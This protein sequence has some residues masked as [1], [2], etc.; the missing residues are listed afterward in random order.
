MKSKLLASLI[1]LCGL[2]SFAVDPV[3]VWSGDFNET[4]KGDYTLSANGNTVAADGLSITISTAK[5]VSVKKTAGGN[6]GDQASTVIIKYTNFT[7]PTNSDAQVL[8]MNHTANTSYKDFIGAASISGGN[9]H[10][11]WQNTTW[12]AN[13]TTSGAYGS[14]AT[15]T[16]TFAFTWA[17]TGT[18]G[19]YF[20]MDGANKN[21]WSTLHGN[22]Q[23]DGVWVGGPNESTTLKPATGMKVLAIAVFDSR[24]SDAEIAAY[25]FPAPPK[26]VES[27]MLLN[28]HNGTTVDGWLNHTQS[29]GGAI[30]NSGSLTTNGIL[31]VT[32]SEGNF[33]TQR[34]SGT[35]FLSGEFIGL[36]GKTY[37]SIAS[38]VS[39]SLGLPTGVV[40]DDT[41]Y[42]TGVMNGGKVNHTATLSGLDNS[43][44]YLLYIGCG[45]DHTDA[46][47]QSGFKFETS[48]CASVDEL[49]YVN[50]ESTAYQ[51]GNLNTD[52]L[53]TTD[54]LLIV[55]VKGI[56][57]VNGTIQFKMVG[58]RSSLNFLAV[59]KMNDVATTAELSYEGDVNVS[60]IN[61][62]LKA[63][64]NKAEVTLQSGATIYFD[65]ELQVPTKLICEG[66]IMI[67]ANAKPTDLTKLDLSG[68]TDSVTRTWLTDSEKKGIGF[69]FASKRGPVTSAALVTDTAWYDNNDGGSNDEGKN[70]TNVAM[71]S[72]GLTT[73]TWTSANTYDDDA[74]TH[75]NN[76]SASM[77]RGYLDDANGVSITVKNIPFAEY[78]VII[79]ASTDDPNNPKLTHKVVNG[80][81]YTYD[82]TCSDVAKVG[83][84]AWGQ[85]RSSSTVAY[86]TNAIR[87]I[88]QTKGTLTITSP[89]N[90]SINARGCVSAI[91]IVPYSSFFPPSAT[92]ASV[93]SKCSEDYKSNTISGVMENIIL[94]SWTGDMTARVVVNS[95]VYES[96]AITDNAFTIEVTGLDRETVYRTVLEVGYTD[97]GIFNAVA[98]QPIALY[99]GEQKFVWIASPF[100]I[101]EKTL[102]NNAQGLTIENPFADPDYIDLCDSEFTVSISAS[103]AVDA[104]ND[105]VLDGT[106]QGGVRIAQ[107]SSGLK[108]QVVVDGAW[109]DFANAAVDTTY[110]LKV[111]FHYEKSQ[112]GET[113]A[114]S[115]TYALDSATKT[116]TN[117]TG[118]LKVTEIFVSDGTN[119]SNDML[120]A[121]QLDKAV[122]VDIE[123]EP[124]DE[125]VGIE[126]DND[127]EAQKIA[128]KLKVGISEAVAAVLTTAAQ[129]EEYRAYFK[130]V[131]VKSADGTYTAQVAFAD[132][133]ED[134]IEK[135]I[136]AAIDD[137]VDSFNTGADVTMT[138]KPGLYYGVKRG[139]SLGNMNTVETELATSDKVTIKITKPEGASAHFYRI[140]VSPTPETK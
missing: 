68:V 33:F 75:G 44:K 78:A 109:T 38:E 36:D 60:D 79:Y 124:G 136:A 72:D 16:K 119:L 62:D 107:T 81:N 88:K 39:S 94:N 90:T 47:Y 35:S 80:T 128:A 123:I 4:T 71:S 137:V 127:V 133:V 126:A 134:D 56:K 105:A 125:V 95:T 85:G 87:V 91:Q 48:G 46:D 12:G 67:S 53:S 50:T 7:P 20:W 8:I 132:G 106:E 84:D 11:I 138:A 59:A 130:I 64:D 70:G 97:G 15:D 74:S 101:Q 58:G 61:N 6:I 99:Q 32:S 115:V 89:K 30:P 9:I 41:V 25:E 10:G 54:S 43:T 86:G 66:R 102:V 122:I 63:T 65:A 5:G 1:A 21:G 93:V 110:T 22:L 3:A 29:S 100:V 111:K 113:D 112:E 73:I 49:A 139:N 52:M 31:F 104:E 92:I 28:I 42:N 135:D 19:A 120:G 37:D 108:L 45:R 18:A 76:S 13:K 103:E 51:V 34:A 117:P 14:A 23:V 114:T 98:T 24:I 27:L 118:K 140:I 129:K 17:Q 83:T 82:S 57:P 96:E 131:A 40:F 121:C 116:S 26:K 69:N 2:T 77:V 55:R